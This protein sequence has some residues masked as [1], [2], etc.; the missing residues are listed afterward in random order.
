ML[1]FAV[2]TMAIFEVIAP[3]SAF[4]VDTLGC[5]APFGHRDK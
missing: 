3:S 4:N 2:G 1:P 5:A